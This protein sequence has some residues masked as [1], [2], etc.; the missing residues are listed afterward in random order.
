M[1]KVLFLAIAMLLAT[2]CAVKY[3]EHRFNL[4]TVQK[5]DQREAATRNTTLIG[6]SVEMSGESSILPT[7]RLGYAST[8]EAQSG[9]MKE[10]ETAVPIY[11]ES[12]SNQKTEGTK[13]TT[14][15][16]QSTKMN[17]GKNGE[18]TNKQ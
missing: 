17:W 11:I 13:V 12:H 1:K 5:E 9:R 7:I 16:G 8:S 10:K 3:G 15:V 14:D 2:G 18:H 6:L 4:L